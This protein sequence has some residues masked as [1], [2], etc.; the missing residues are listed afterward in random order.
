VVL[1]AELDASPV[2]PRLV[3]EA[4]AAESAA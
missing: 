4:F 3:G 2:A 1:A